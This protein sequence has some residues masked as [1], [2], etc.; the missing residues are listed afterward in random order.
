MTNPF[1]R[2]YVE[3]YHSKKNLICYSSK[4]SEFVKNI[5]EFGYT[6]EDLPSDRRAEKEHEAPDNTKFTI[7]F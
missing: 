1:N 7:P 5:Q 4:S 3:Q 6:H 2:I